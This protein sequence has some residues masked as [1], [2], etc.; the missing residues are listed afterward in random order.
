MK[1][2]FS[3]DEVKAGDYVLCTKYSDRDPQDQWQVGFI[4]SVEQDGKQLL[5]MLKDPQRSYFKCCWLIAPNE[6][7][8]IIESKNP[9]L[10]V[11]E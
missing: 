7:R 2:V 9:R 10:V 11:E 8:E 3:I 4:E 1:R 6:G 5:F